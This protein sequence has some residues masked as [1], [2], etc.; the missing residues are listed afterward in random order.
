MLH[1]DEGEGRSWVRVFRNALPKT[2]SSG[3]HDSGLSLPGA[4]RPRP[5]PA[6]QRRTRLTLSKLSSGCADITLSSV[7]GA[8]AG[9]ACFSGLELDEICELRW[10]DLTWRDDSDA[11]FCEVRSASG[12]ATGRR[13]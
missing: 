7:D 12:E 4:G 11:T 5:S 6:A 9:L 8:I 3:W 13:A 10:S 1:L 2:K